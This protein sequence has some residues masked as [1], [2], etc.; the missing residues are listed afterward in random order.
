M[1]ISSL[2]LWLTSILCKHGALESS[3]VSTS[4]PQHMGTVQTEASLWILS[5]R[6]TAQTTSLFALQHFHHQI[7]SSLVNSC[8]IYC[9]RLTSWSWCPAERLNRHFRPMSYICWL[10]DVSTLPGENHPEFGYSRCAIQLH[11]HWRI[12]D[13]G[14][15][16]LRIHFYPS[17]NTQL[18]F[19]DI[20]NLSHFNCEERCILT[21]F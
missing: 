10:T 7:F 20:K 6:R 2:H 15:V 19:L 17:E 16:I 5:G 11:C 14:L 3:V 1:E 8:W 12:Q 4:G 13:I 18:L 21:V 9:W